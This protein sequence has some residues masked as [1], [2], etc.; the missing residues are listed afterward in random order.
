MAVVALT[1]YLLYL[2]LAFGVRTVL[3]RRRTGSTGFRGLTGR[4]GSAPWWGGVLF[5]AALVAGP[6]GPLL[7]LAGVL[8]PVPP[9]DHPAAAVLGVAL[10]VVGI[11]V[12][13]VAQHAMGTAWRVG[14]DSGEST[15]LVTDGVFAHVRNPVFT[16]M[17]VTGA[18]LALTAADPV[19]LLGLVALL[20][21]VHLQVRAV[22][23]PHLLALHGEVYRAYTARTGRFL[24]RPRRPVARG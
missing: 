7:Q 2:L 10:A 15:A 9:L 20:V 5:V 24:P 16:A 23:E 1:L 21:A 18:G 8:A 13:L 12:T 14:V 4:P 22:E 19:S 3:H 6:L 17:I 11:A